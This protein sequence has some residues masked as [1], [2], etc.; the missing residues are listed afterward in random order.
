MFPLVSDMHVQCM[1]LWKDDEIVILLFS[2]LIIIF[3]IFLVKKLLDKDVLDVVLA[4]R[5][6]DKLGNSLVKPENYRLV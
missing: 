4:M 5:R 1:C 3:L 6:L 2:N